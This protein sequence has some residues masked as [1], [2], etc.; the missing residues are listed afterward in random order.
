MKLVSV[1]GVPKPL[2]AIFCIAAI[3]KPEDRDYSFSRLVS[4]VSLLISLTL[5]QRELVFRP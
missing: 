3:E 1:V 2:E 5:W 4:F